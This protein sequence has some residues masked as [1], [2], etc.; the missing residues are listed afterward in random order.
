MMYAIAGSVAMGAS[1]LHESQLDR[2]IRQL[3]ASARKLIDFFT[4]PL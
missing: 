1:Q 3:K 2:T 4:N